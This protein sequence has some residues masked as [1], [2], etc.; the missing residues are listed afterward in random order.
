MFRKGLIFLLTAVVS[1]CAPTVEPIDYGKDQCDFCRMTIADN[2][3]AAQ[4][5]TRKGKNYKFDAI[6]CM[7]WFLQ[8]DRVG[9]KDIHT[10]LVA[11][12]SHPGTMIAARTAVYLISPQIKSPMGAQ[13][14]AFPDEA[15]A[16]KFQQKLGG[17]IYHWEAL[18]PVVKAR[19]KTLQMHS[20]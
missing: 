17:E 3:F 1:A 4:L 11:D 15:T 16:Q 12:Y 9:M 2:H 18:H 14:A 13:L 20:H 6:E 19:K 10:M 7:V 5:V 8:D